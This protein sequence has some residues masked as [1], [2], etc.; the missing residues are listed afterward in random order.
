[1]KL[2]TKRPKS[3]LNVFLTAQF[4]TGIMGE[5]GDK[6]EVDEEVEAMKEQEE[7]EKRIEEAIADEKK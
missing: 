6:C 7:Q 2:E 3:Y 5:Q 1:M 4:Y